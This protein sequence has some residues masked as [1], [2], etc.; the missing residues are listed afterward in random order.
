[1]SSICPFLR[2]FFL[3]F[4]FRPTNHPSQNPRHLTPIRAQAPQNLTQDIPQATANHTHRKSAIRAR[5]ERARPATG[6][7]HRNT[8]NPPP[9]KQEQQKT[10]DARCTKPPKMHYKTTNA[11]EVTPPRHYSRSSGII[12]RQKSRKTKLEPLLESSHTAQTLRASLT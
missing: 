5:T 4:F 12:D 9:R 3:F 6:L 8:Q 7:G 10:R 2:D 1:M 11:G